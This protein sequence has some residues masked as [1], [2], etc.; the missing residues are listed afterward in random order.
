MIRLLPCNG[1]G[2]TDFEMY[3]KLKFKS[4]I[5]FTWAKQERKKNAN[6]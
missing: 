2:D 3:I 6:R 4:E 5:L 1:F